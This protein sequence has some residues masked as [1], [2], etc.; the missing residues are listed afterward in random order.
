MWL[1]ADSGLVYDLSKNVQQWSDG[2]GKNNHFTQENSISKPLWKDSVFN[3]KPALLFNGSSTYL[4]SL[5]KIDFRQGFTFFIIGKNNVRKNYNGLFRLAATPLDS[6]V[7]E[8]GFEAGGTDNGSGT[9]NYVAN[10]DFGLRYFQIPNAPPAINN[11]YLYEIQVRT[12]SI[13]IYINNVLVSAIASVPSYIPTLALNAYLGID[14]E[15]GSNLNGAINEVLIYEQSIS[16][17]DRT[18]I[19]SYLNEK[20]S[21]KP[22][23]GI[24]TTLTSFCSHTISLDKPYDNYLW[25]T[26]DTV[27]SITINKSGTY[28]VSAMDIFGFWS[29]DTILVTYPSS[30]PPLANSFLCEGKNLKWNTLLPKN[31]YSFQWQDNSSDSIFTITQ[32]GKYYVKVMDT[33]GC[34]ITSDTVNIQL[35]NYP[36]AATLGPDTTFCAG[37]TIALA[38][39]ALQTKTYQWSTGATSASIPVMS[40]GQ[41]SLIATDSLG[42]VAKDTVNITI[43]GIAPKSSFVYN[44]VKCAGDSVVLTDLSAAPSGNTITNYLWSFG[45]ATTSVLPSPK[46]LYLLPD[47]GLFNVKLT[48]T[49]DAGCSKDTTI[50]LHVYPKPA[51]NFSNTLAC[52]GNTAKFTSILNL[53]GYA[54]QSYLWNFA[55]LGSG[56]NNSSTLVN[57]THLFANPGGYL[58]KYVVKNNKGCSDSLTKPVVVQSTPQVNFTTSVTCEKQ[59]VYFTDSSSVLSPAILQS[60][61]T[62]FGDGTPVGTV[63]NPIHTY[64]I[65]GPYLVKYI[66]AANNGCSDT[67]LKTLN[68]NSKPIAKIGLSGPYC[69]NSSIGFSDSSVVNLS[70]TANWKWT[71]DGTINSTLKKTSSTF[72][73][74][75]TH[76]A[77]LVVASVEG[78]K[79]STTRTFTINGLPT[80]GFDFSPLFGNPPLTVNFTDQSVGAIKYKW[81]FG[82]TGTSTLSAPTHIYQDTGLY[83]INLVITDS[84]GCTNTISKSFQIQNAVY[85][86]ALLQV[87]AA[88][89]ADNFL[90]ISLSFGNKSTRPLTTAD[91]VVDI[92]GDNGFKETWNGNLSIAGLTS[93]TLSTAPR[94]NTTTEHNYVCVTAKKPNGF[95]D[96]Y[97]DDNQICVGLKSGS[98]ILPDPNP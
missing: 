76:N 84:K 12:D 85:D 92:E 68:I 70:S 86:M 50:Q 46:H 55:D 11:F 98:F 73:T 32:A 66:V 39:G 59:K 6:S 75:G 83:I 61:S 16:N 19:Y 22:Y 89:D 37:N 27:S 47:T 80:P 79:D 62:N 42:C 31:M 38:A 14:Y 69:V 77:K 43:S 40:S 74:T 57:P 64:T 65:I 24:D 45:D 78:C 23:L 18:S 96:I 88:V 51:V 29:S 30:N 91:F 17:V 82:D 95:Q 44:S 97:P 28:W 54:A 60:F 1:K 56:A 34:S 15:G 36:I 26:G 53:K 90:N 93:Y 13:K 20:Y 25:S 58:V 81:N 41:Y 10:R 33:S 72:T 52:S 48:V 3:N 21:G 49:T 87:Q 67:I 63:K 71:F 9:F 2:S 5:L 4:K 94:L 7:L 8:M 35:N